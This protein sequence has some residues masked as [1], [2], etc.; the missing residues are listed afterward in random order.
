MKD[1]IKQK[2]FESLIPAIDASVRDFKKLEYSRS[3]ISE[4]LREMFFGYDERIESYIIN[5][6]Y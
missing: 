5:L 1:I 6:G 3:E 2:G 4:T